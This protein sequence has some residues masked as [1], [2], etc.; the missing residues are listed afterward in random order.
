VFAIATSS[1]DGVVRFEPHRCAVQARTMLDDA[2]RLSRRGASAVRERL[3][4][5]GFDL[6]VQPILCLPFSGLDRP[7]YVDGVI[8]TRHQHLDY[9][10]RHWSG[11]F[12]TDAQAARVFAALQPRVHRA[13]A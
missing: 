5:R 1:D 11:H 12:L 9:L 8:V 2:L 6:R 10:I 13:A 7:Q 3:H 4:D